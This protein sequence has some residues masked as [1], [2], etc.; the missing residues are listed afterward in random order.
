MQRESTIRQDLLYLIALRKVGE[1]GNLSTVRLVEQFGSPKR[2]FEAS[3]QELQ[4]VLKR[5]HAERIRSFR[6]WREVESTLKKIEREAIEVITIWDS[7]YPNLLREIYDPPVILFVKGSLKEFDNLCFA[8]VGSRKVTDYGRRVTEKFSYELASLGITI[9]S[10]MARGVDSLAHRSALKADGRTVA[11]LGS[12]LLRIYPPENRALAEEI[13]ERG[14]LISEFF[15]EEPPKR[16]NFPR[17]NRI[18]SGMSI[19]VLVTEASLKSGAL[20]TATYA[21]EQGREVFAVPG[22]INS[23]NSQ[24]TNSLIKRGAKL[25]Q[26]VEDILEEIKYQIEL[27]EES[28]VSYEQ[29]V[30]V[31]LSEDE[32]AIIDEIDRAITL[33][34]LVL[35]TKMD[36][37]SLLD[38][39]L[40]LELKGMIE[41][42][43]GRYHRRI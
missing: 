30:R 26:S 12:G 15:P 1:I 6:G 37:A 31:D 19:G 41:K 9:V 32:Q 29:K 35:K 22:N 13:A 27:P 39:L 16:E 5:E 20:I 21:L 11:V 28:V 34:E 18:I 14:A 33:D 38:V 25:V 42:V 23:E 4:G 17:R 10:G 24:G 36:V 2:V 40:R 3:E 43:E 7:N 8:V